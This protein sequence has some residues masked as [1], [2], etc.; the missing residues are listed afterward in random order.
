MSQ[1]PTSLHKLILIFLLPFIVF[2]ATAQD[3]NASG[4]GFSTGY[5]YW[6]LRDE[7]QSIRNFGGSTVPVSLSFFR[8]RSGK[9]FLIEGSYQKANLSAETSRMTSDMYLAQLN[10]AFQRKF[11]R[12]VPLQVEAGLYLTNQFSSRTYSFNSP[13]AG[14][15]PFTGEFFT[16]P[17]AIVTLDRALGASS[18]LS[19][20]VQY[21]PVAYLFSRDHH[22]IRGFPTLGDVPR[23]MVLLPDFHDLQST[24]QLS[25]QINPRIAIG[26]AY[27]WR[28][29]QYRRGY[30]FQAAN[31]QLEIGFNIM[32]KK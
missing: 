10:L 31:H 12:T 8:N 19:W 9:S 15:D 29:M 1:C 28:Y 30:L 5:S 18:H 4:I 23:G 13:F 27:R 16:S 24:L 26:F 20:Q 25:E 21:S 6:L 32:F 7:L 17:A 2:S 14:Q 11:S 22:P 3:N